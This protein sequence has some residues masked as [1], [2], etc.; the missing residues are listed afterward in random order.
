[1]KV[2]LPEDKKLK[3]KENCRYLLEN[4]NCSIQFLASF[5]GLLVST[6]N[7][8]DY[9][10][11]HYR[12]LERDKIMALKKSRGNYDSLA[13]LADESINEIK[14]WL[15]NI[16]ASFRNIRRSEPDL[17][18]CTDASNDGWGAV[19]GKESTGGRWLVCEKQLHINI[20]EIKAVYF[21]LKALSKF[22]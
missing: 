9:G 10:A 7:A 8:V 22:I 21:G 2:F 17:I 13:C 5:I 6:F 1:M 16:D 11:L 20:L 18:L 3:I 12:D 14:W 4:Q 15:E 19:F